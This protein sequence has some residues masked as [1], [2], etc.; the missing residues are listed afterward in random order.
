MSQ[1]HEVNFGEHL[2]VVEKLPISKTLYLTPLK[3]EQERLIVDE[4]NKD[5]FIDESDAIVNKLDEDLK[6]FNLHRT[7]YS[8]VT[9]LTV[10]KD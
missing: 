8:C 7:P 5:K 1:Y 9:L 2:N 10:F 4:Y 6:N 3:H